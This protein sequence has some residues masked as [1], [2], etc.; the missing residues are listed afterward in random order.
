MYGLIK[1]L[2][3]LVNRYMSNKKQSEDCLFLNVYTPVCGPGGPAHAWR[4]GGAQVHAAPDNEEPAM[5]P[6]LFWVHGG[7]FKYGDGNHDMLS[8]ELFLEKG[9]L[10]VTINYRLGPFG[11]WWSGRDITSPGVSTDSVSSLCCCGRQGS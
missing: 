4:H 10:V 9:V 1:N 2:P 7:A 5:R 11:G 8:P 6:V 3:V